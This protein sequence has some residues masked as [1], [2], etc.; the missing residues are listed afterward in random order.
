MAFVAAPNCFSLALRMLLDNQ[1]VENTFHYRVSAPASRATLENAIT[2][3]FNYYALHT[4]FFGLGWYLTSG[5]ARALDSQTAPSAELN[6]ST[7]IQGSDASEMQPNNVSFA[8]TRYTGLAGRANRGRVYHPSITRDVM[9]GAN[10]MNASQALGFIG[11]Y[12]GLMAQM[13]SGTAAATEIILSRSLGTH[14][15]VVA[16]RYA[17]LNLDSQ[18][19]RLPGHNIHH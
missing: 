2:T 4:G 3:A 14:H 1:P 9:S 5:Y 6:P 7:V 16:Y 8:I 19:R 18:R 10:A 11:F 12:N 17:D 15:D 13:L